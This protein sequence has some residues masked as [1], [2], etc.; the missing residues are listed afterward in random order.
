MKNFVIKTL[1]NAVALGVAAWVVT[2][3]HLGADETSWTGNALTAVI[4]ALIFGVV[5]AVLGP[6]ARFLSFPA[7]VLTLGLFTFVVNAF[8]LQVTSW[9]SGAIGLSFSIANFFWDAVFGS[10]IITI[11]SWGISLVL[12]DRED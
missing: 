5:N 1:V 10:V 7:R 3:I 9:L 4:V 2:G 8:L 12:P 11:V 6:I